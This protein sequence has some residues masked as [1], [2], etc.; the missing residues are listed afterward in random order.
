[1][2]EH[3]LFSILSNDAGVTALVGSRIY[4]IMLPQNATFPCASYS[5]D[6]GQEDDT[7]DGQGTFQQINIEVD[8]WAKTHAEMLT[9]GGAIKAAL[10]NYSGTVSGVTIDK[11][12]IESSVCVYEDASEA[13]R[14]TWVITVFKR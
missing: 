7:F 10:K 9:V 4:P 8:A 12:R 5:T 11:I 6:E 1:M 2:I 13:F 3:A 14:K